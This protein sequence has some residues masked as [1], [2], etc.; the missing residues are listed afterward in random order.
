MSNNNTYSISTESTKL[1]IE[2]FNIES[3]NNEVP[4]LSYGKIKPFFFFHNDP[5]F[6]IGS[7]CTK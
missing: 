2:N 7:D 6:A 5:L 3:L 4:L 1:N